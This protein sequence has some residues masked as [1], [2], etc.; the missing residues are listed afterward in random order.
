MDFDAFNAGVDFGG[1]RSK[2]D[3]RV[4]LC[5]LLCQ[6]K[7]PL[8]QNDIVAVLC[9]NGFANYFE[10]VDSLSVLTSAGS[11]SKDNEGN[12]ISNDLTSEIAVR[13]GTTLPNSIREQAVIFATELLAAAKRARENKVIISET[14]NGYQIECHISGGK[15]DL[16]SFTLYVPNLQQA[17][18][19]EKNFLKDPEVF[20][21]AILALSTANTDM[22]KSII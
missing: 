11:V 21:R 13:L 2:S 16:M 9:E 7:A 14:E 1:L 19:V 3:I 6:V 4:L 22:L 15:Q 20:Y 12:F 5:Y 17:K 10:V 18:L 8:S